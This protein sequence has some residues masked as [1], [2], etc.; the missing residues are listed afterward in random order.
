MYQLV[1]SSKA[2]TSLSQS[3]VD[4]ILE[5]ARK[6]NQQSAITGFLLFDGASFLQLL[7]G[8]ERAV[9]D[10]FERISLDERHNKVEA[11]IQDRARTRL[12]S[13][14]S[15]AYAVVDEGG[16]TNFGG[17]LRRDSILELAACMKSRDSFVSETIRDF[18]LGLCEKAVAA[19]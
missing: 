11:L 2:T 15:M 6:N 10:L 4:D 12:F 14:W 3:S 8:E 18:M 7:E 17:S 19:G 16:L 9:T 5:K 1:Y 13:N